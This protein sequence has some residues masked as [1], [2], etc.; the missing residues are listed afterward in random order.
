M[1]AKGQPADRRLIHDELERV[2]ADLHRLVAEAT[3]AELRRRTDGTRWT[4][5]QM[6]FHMVFGT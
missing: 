6:L 2:R 5:Q 4:N 3:A 1:T